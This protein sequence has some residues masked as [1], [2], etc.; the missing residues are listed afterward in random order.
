M[1]EKATRRRLSPRDKRAWF[2]Y[3]PVS[4][5]ARA[6]GI[7]V[8]D[9][10]YTLIP[11]GSPYPPFR[12]PEDHHFTWEQGRIL[13]AYQF[14]HITRGEGVFESG[15]SGLQRIRA[16]DLFIVFPGIWHRYRPDPRTGWDEYW[17]EFDGDT[18]RRMMDRKP[19]APA[20]PVLHVGHHEKLV[21]LFLEAVEIL[22][23][24]PPEHQALLGALAAQVVAHT[25]SAV[26]RQRFEGRP[27]EEIVRE[28]KDLLA[29]QAGRGHPLEGVAAQLNLS[30]SAFRRLF[31]AGTGYSP[32][33]F[34]LQ[35]C[36]Q[37][38]KDLLA[39]TQ[40]PVGRIAEELGFD[41]IFYFSRLFKRKTGLSP[42][43]HR[44]R[45]ARRT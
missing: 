17:L 45:T 21:A 28:A 10:G 42:A 5:D 24:E 39:R 41:S 44:R 33:Q 7:Y 34:A 20:E 8:P 32:H 38:A 2:R 31:K 27:V 18:A 1:N 15:P 11:P 25:L 14:V 37:R 26:R 12:H 23:H 29:R 30:Y 3:L 6:W 35:V 19:F 9:A 4:P 36:L 43:A 16:G 40:L 22:R 13:A